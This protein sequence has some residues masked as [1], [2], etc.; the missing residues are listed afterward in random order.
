MYGVDHTLIDQTSILRFIEYNWGLG[1]IG[2]QSFDV[3]AGPIDNMFN[4]IIYKPENPRSY[5]WNA[6]K[7][8]ITTGWRIRALRS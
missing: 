2:N 7:H 1:R 4:F 6:N 8:K 3:K 5:N